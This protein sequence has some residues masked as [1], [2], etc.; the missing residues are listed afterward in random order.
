MDLLR[1][2]LQTRAQHVDVIL[3]HH[4]VQTVGETLQHLRSAVDGE[5][6]AYLEEVTKPIEK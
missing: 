1:D 2:A 4:H 6:L 5:L 3:H